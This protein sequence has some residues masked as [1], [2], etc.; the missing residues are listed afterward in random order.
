MECF[1][2]IL[3]RLS[4]YQYICYYHNIYGNLQKKIMSHS[5]Q[6]KTTFNFVYWVFTVIFVANEFPQNTSVRGVK[7]TITVKKKKKCFKSKQL[8]EKKGAR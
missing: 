6:I 7:R 8:P 1:L 3:E 4:Q 2:G 5:I